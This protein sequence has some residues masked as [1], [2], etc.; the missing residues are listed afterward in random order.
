MLRVEWVLGTGLK[1]VNELDISKSRSGKGRVQ[2]ERSQWLLGERK[3]CR[4]VI[5]AAVIWVEVLS[6]ND[7]A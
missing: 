3:T 6:T 4:E 7:G 5:Q 1:R 2:L